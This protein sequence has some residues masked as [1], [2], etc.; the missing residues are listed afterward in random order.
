MDEPTAALTITEVE[1]LFGIART[2][3][4]TQG[5]AVLFVS[6]RLEEIFDLC[7]RVTV[8]RDGSHVWTKPIEELTTA[9]I[10]RAM[11]GRDMDALFP[12][13]QAERGKAVL[14]VE[15]LTREGVFTDVSF[16]VHA[17]EIVALAGLVGAGTERG[18]AGDLRHRPRRRRLGRR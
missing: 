3:C 17:G 13:E 8:M 1:R 9:S 4:A 2:L 7:Q 14:Q 6:H 16:D 15:R 5:A 18:R 12:K 11:V 10:I